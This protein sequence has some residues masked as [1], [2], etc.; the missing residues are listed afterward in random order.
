[1]NGIGPRS[2]CAQQERGGEDKET[3]LH[4]IGAGEDET[5][6]VTVAK[7]SRGAISNFSCRDMSTFRLG[8]VI[9]ERLM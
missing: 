3:R 9:F 4:D 2:G 7:K 5:A 1:L 8:I 6:A